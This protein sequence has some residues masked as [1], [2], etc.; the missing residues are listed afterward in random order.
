M[1]VWEDGLYT[2]LGEFRNSEIDKVRSVCFRPC[3]VF[4]DGAGGIGCGCCGS[5]LG[6]GKKEGEG[7]R[8]ESFL[9]YALS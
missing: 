7:D 8:E 9:H 2:G 3:G 1:E 4:S 5:G 6:E